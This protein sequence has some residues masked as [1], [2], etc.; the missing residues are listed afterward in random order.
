MGGSYY[1]KN[2]IY[3]RC[4]LLNG[5]GTV[6]VENKLHLLWRSEDVKDVLLVDPPRPTRR[7]EIH[8]RH[9]SDPVEAIEYGTCTRCRE[10]MIS[11]KHHPRLKRHRH[12]EEMRAKEKIKTCPDCHMVFHILADRLEYLIRE[13]YP[14]LRPNDRKALSALM[15]EHV[16]EFDELN[17]RYF[18]LSE[19]LSDEDLYEIV[20]QGEVML[21]ETNRLLKKKRR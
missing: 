21:R 18:E 10:W 2:F 12:P 16:W 1:L 20:A 19:D 6:I 15:R 5:S 4:D 9:W 8:K 3:W 13:R 14:L 7:S 17:R 11:E